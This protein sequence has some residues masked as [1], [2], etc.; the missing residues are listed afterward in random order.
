MH[1]I[2]Q[3]LFFRGTKCDVCSRVFP[4]RLGKQA[5]VC[6]DC[7][8]TTHKQCHTK[9]NNIEVYHIIICD[10][11]YDKYNILLLYNDIMYHA[12]NKDALPDN[13]PRW[14][15]IVYRL[16]FQIWNCEYSIIIIRYSIII[17]QYSTV[18]L[19]YSTVLLSFRNIFIIRIVQIKDSKI[20][21]L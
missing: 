16:L 9:V 7:G 15:L 4:L 13:I 11:W 6:R 8:V 14:R 21:P 2:Y 18:L 20:L 17:I 19:S 10:T 5:Y 12:M 1:T 3:T